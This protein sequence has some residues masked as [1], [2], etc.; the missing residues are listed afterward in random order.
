MRPAIT[1]NPAEQST[2]HID[3]EHLTI[4]GEKVTVFDCAS[5]V[6][7]PVL[8]TFVRLFVSFT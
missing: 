7:R 4:S 5:Q 3:V 2:V 6:W 8:S 1:L